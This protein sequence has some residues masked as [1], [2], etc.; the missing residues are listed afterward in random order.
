MEA[1]NLRREGMRVELLCKNP[2]KS[3]EGYLELAARKGIS[4]VYEYRKQEGMVLL[5]KEKGR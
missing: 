4:M 1:C 3:T 5:T 2:E